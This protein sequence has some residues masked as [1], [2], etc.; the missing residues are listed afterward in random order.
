M[1]THF[2]RHFTKGNPLQ[3]LKVI[4]NLRKKAYEQALAPGKMFLHK[5][6]FF[7][8]NPCGALPSAPWI[9]DF[10]SPPLKLYRDMWFH[11]MTPFSQA[12]DFIVEG[13]EKAL[14]SDVDFSYNFYLKEYERDLAFDKIP[15]IKIPNLY[16]LAYY[17]GDVPYVMYLRNNAECRY[18]EYSRLLLRKG[19]RDLLIP[20]KQLPFVQ[21][22]NVYASTTPMDATIS[23]G[24]DR[25]TF[26][27]DALEDSKMECT[28]LRRCSEG[29]VLI[30]PDRGPSDRPAPYTR[31]TEEKYTPPVERSNVDHKLKYKF[32][33]RFH[34]TI[35]TDKGIPAGPYNRT[36]Q[37]FDFYTWLMGLPDLPVS[38]VSLPSDHVFLGLEND[39]TD[40][41][42]KAGLYSTK[43]S[44]L[45]NYFILS[46]KV[47][48][49][50]KTNL[51]SYQQ[52]MVGIDPHSE[53]L[54][55]RISKYRT[56][57]LRRAG[58]D[59]RSKLLWRT[60]V[61]IK[62]SLTGY[63]SSN[64][65]PEVSEQVEAMFD[66]VEKKQIQ[67]LQNV[68]IPNSNTVDIVEY[69]DTQ[70]KYNTGYTYLVTAYELSVGTEYFYSQMASEP[71]PKLCPEGFRGPVDRVGP[72]TRDQLRPIEAILRSP[73][74]SWREL[75]AA[76]VEEIRKFKPKFNSD[77]ERIG[78]WFAPWTDEIYIISYCGE[79]APPGKF[80][81]IVVLPNL[82]SDEFGGSA[83]DPEMPCK[84]FTRLERYRA[85]AEPS[86][87]ISDDGRMR[88]GLSAGSDI[89]AT[90]RLPDVRTKIGVKK[91]PDIIDGKVA[92]KSRTS[93]K[94]FGFSSEV[95]PVEFEAT[96]LAKDILAAT[97]ECP[98][99]EPCRESFLVTTIPTLK[100]HQVPYFVWS[101]EVTDAYPVGPDVEIAP[102]RADNDEL[103][104]LVGAGVS[105]YRAKPI[106]IRPGA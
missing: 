102:Y 68:W 83:A 42:L 17:P 31:S 55:Y 29:E 75:Y 14:H 34:S 24:T 36:L 92:T 94:D 10:K 39:S 53:A 33:K 66:L 52:M 104:F 77:A 87:E 38:S 20:I 82:E 99:P 11:L 89:I 105:S 1:R 106:P 62:G 58:F 61:D 70:V 41:A 60:G 30:S 3:I 80:S 12:E 9:E 46:G 37:T 51:R 65:L 8:E 50:A 25:S 23:F 40:M 48:D 73:P 59:V 100:V 49:I 103:L 18:R 22:K 93:S 72:L 97:C 32:A 78:I 35:D 67:P 85:L 98:P 54:L 7:G 63:N 74:P 44:Y 101:G 84:I 76:V 27:A 21:D 69:V 16:L 43:L 91:C 15:E 71:A 13:K 56:E 64:N 95:S 5:D 88:I 47:N 79:W 81:V 26:I 4:I 19:F 45:A 6:P 96:Y 57:D 86:P 28:M 2:R 90:T